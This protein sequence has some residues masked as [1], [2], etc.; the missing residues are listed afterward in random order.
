MDLQ[1]IQVGDGK[2][3]ERGHL[4]VERHP[5]HAV[6]KEVEGMRIRGRKR[7][8]GRITAIKNGEVMSHVEVTI[9]DQAITSVITRDSVEEM[10]LAVGFP[11]FVLIKSTEVMLFQE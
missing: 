9:G 10:E 6:A 1:D 2:C 11:I 4:P 7:L 8:K 5:A 3:G